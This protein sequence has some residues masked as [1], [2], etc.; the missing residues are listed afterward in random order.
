MAL[1]ESSSVW[2]VGRGVTALVEHVDDHTVVWLRGEY[3]LA[4]VPALAEVL[5]R[6]MAIDDADLFVDLAQVQFMDAST[7]DVLVRA[8]AFLDQRSR[9]L[10]LQAP[11][12]PAARVLE[13]CELMHVVVPPTSAFPPVSATGGALGTWVA[14]PTEQRIRPR[15]GVSALIPKDSIDALRAQLSTV[16]ESGTG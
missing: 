6:A 1:V 3:D 8:H 4:S 10:W 9:S 16:A 15:G 7:V 2:V 5:A 13:V 12:G 14:V 11:S